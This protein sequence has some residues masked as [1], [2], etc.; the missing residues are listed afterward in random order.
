MNSLFD[1]KDELF[2]LLYDHI[3][4]G[5]AVYRV[6]NDGA[7]GSDYI[8]KRFNREALRIEQKTLGE[9]VGKSL[10]DLRPSIDDFGL[11]PV[12]REVWKSGQAKKFETRLYH[13]NRFHAWYENTVFKLPSGEIVAIYNDVTE[14]MQAQQ[15]LEEAYREKQ[16]YIEKAPYGIFVADKHGDYV[17]VNQAACDMTGYSRNELLSMNLRDLSSDAERADGQF[18]DA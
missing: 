14:K 5:A 12:F 17:E 4:S 16:I 6:I 11:I 1:E 15:A 8:I 18:N 7:F 9:V 10:K 13:D 2:Q 3:P